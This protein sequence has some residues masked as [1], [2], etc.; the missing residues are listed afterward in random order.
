MWITHWNLEPSFSRHGKD[1]NDTGFSMEGQG[2]FPDHSAPRLRKTRCSKGKKAS[3]DRAEKAF[4]RQ[5]SFLEISL[6]NL[7]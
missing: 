3:N 5:M 4:Y 2:P 7:G 6:L 1:R